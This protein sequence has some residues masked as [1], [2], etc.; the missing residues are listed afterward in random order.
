M[1]GF[2]SIVTARQIIEEWEFKIRSKTISGEDCDIFSNPSKKELNEIGDQ[3]RFL[4]NA[5]D[6]TIYVWSFSLAF[7]RDVAGEL[8]NKL[9]GKNLLFGRGEKKGSSYVSD[10]IDTAVSLDILRDQDWSWTEK[11]SIDITP[12][13]EKILSRLR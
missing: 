3:I 8:R 7:H 1:E 5:D 11:Y 9:R 12:G 13:I 4:V 2:M 6:K 10:D